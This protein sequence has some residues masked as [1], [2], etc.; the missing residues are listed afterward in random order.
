MIHTLEYRPDDGSVQTITTDFDDDL[1]KV[2]ETVPEAIVTLTGVLDSGLFGTWIFRAG[3][4][5]IVDQ[6]EEP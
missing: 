3:R 1:R 5:T 4:L 2:I 6:R